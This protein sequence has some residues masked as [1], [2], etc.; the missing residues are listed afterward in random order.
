MLR[1]LVQDSSHFGVPKVRVGVRLAPNTTCWREHIF[2]I[3]NGAASDHLITE[4]GAGGIATFNM[5]LSTSSCDLSPSGEIMGLTFLVTAEVW[6]GHSLANLSY[7]GRSI[8][9][10][11]IALYEV[12]AAL[13]I[14]A[15]VLQA[16]LCSPSAFL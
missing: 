1:V 16:D 5:T 12:M 2:L 9:P 13:A 7:D 8:Q 14:A 6:D 4:T 10:A 11:L 3:D 15:P